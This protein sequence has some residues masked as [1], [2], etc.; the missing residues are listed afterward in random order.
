VRDILLLALAGAVGTLSRYGLSGWAYR[1]FG[2]RFPWGTLVV[3]VIGCFLLGLAMHVGTATELIPRSARL[4][5]TVGFLGAF[6]TFSTFG[7]ETHRYMESGAFLPA[8]A[9][10]A[11]NVVLGFAAVWAGTGLGRVAFGGA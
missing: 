5:M 8:F 4:A 7:F 9:N 6:T 1:L 11:A 3:N 10:V 2:E